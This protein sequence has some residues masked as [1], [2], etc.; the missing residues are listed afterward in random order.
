MRAKT[1]PHVEYE[2]FKLVLNEID[3]TTLKEKMV[4]GDNPK[5]IRDA[6]KR[7]NKGITSAAKLIKNLCDRR[8]HRLPKDHVD[9]EVKA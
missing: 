9:Y 3:I 6:E 2:I 5:A 7:F 4:I 1:V 8:T